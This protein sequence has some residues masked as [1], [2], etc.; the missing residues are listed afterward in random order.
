MIQVCLHALPVR[1]EAWI[2]CIRTQDCEPPPAGSEFPRAHRL[3]TDSNAHLLTRSRRDVARTVERAEQT[4][5]KLPSKPSKALKSQPK[6]LHISPLA[7]L[8]FENPV[9]ESYITHPDL[10]YRLIRRD[11]MPIARVSLPSPHTPRFRFQ[12]ALNFMTYPVATPRELPA[13]QSK[14]SCNIF[15]PQHTKCVDYMLGS[16]TFSEMCAER[17]P[18]YS[19]TMMCV[20]SPFYPLPAPDAAMRCLRGKVFHFILGQT[21]MEAE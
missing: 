12:S 4:I 6:P 13:D 11:A 19:P 9:E 18:A 2:A 21:L 7:H 15:A 3:A 16:H 20:D 17:A 10:L 8:G 1:H 14:G 5:D